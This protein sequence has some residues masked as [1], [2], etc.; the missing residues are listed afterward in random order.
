MQLYSSN[1]IETDEIEKT[2]EEI[3]KLLKIKSYENNPDVKILDLEKGKTKIPIEETKKLK[4]WINIK[5]YQEKKKL[6]IIKNAQ[7]LGIDA[8]NSLLKTLEEP[9]EYAVIVL[10]TNSIKS[11]LDT[12]VSRCKIIKLKNSD[13]E[14][15]N[16]DLSLEDIMINDTAQALDNLEIVL[17]DIEG[18]GQAIEIINSLETQLISFKG[19]NK[20][21][22]FD[23]LN[24]IK[25]DLETTNVSVKIALYKLILDLKINNQ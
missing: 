16:T 24:K 11:L 21:H 1:I 19:E 14:E 5:P 13:S 6:I 12:V 3:F 17:K 9:P 10:L 8:Q 23:C 7:Y 4:S 18:K 15:I 2:T 20:P 22:I 25:Q